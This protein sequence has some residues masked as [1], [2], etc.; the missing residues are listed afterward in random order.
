[1]RTFVTGGAGF[2]GSH[3]S[4]HLLELGHEIT[5]LAAEQ[6]DL[7]NIAHLQDRVRVECA[8]LR[9]SARLF[10]IV[11]GAAPQ[12]VYHLAALSSPSDSLQSPRLT[13][14]VN[15]MGTLNLLLACRQVAPDCRFLFVS[16]SEVYGAVSER[17]LPIGEETPLRPANP[18]A[19]SK[20]A[21]EMLASQFFRSYGLPVIRA[22]PFNHTG[23][24]QSEGFVC[25]DFARQLAEIELG[26][27][28]PTL[29]VGNIKVRRDFSDVRDIVRGYRLLLEGGE[30]G[31]VYQLGSGRAVPI[32]EIL[33]ILVGMTSKP[34]Q[35][36]V[37]PSRIRPAEA[38][39]LWGET[40]KAERAVGWKRQY[41]LKATLR[42]L[43]NCWENQLH[44]GAIAIPKGTSILS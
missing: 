28:P 26:L 1:M 2:A 31:E 20:A 42:D 24:R 27:R 25:S 22:R 43:V 15:L 35:V 13:Y 30:P 17:E 12:F 44:A 39:A 23:P 19:G 5:V 36:I 41:D 33:Q 3:L 21:G 40:A 8:D 10:E 32:E 4:E 11:R 6:E 18:Y 16:S 14:E 9:D 37:D 34:V 7:T 29:T 38:P